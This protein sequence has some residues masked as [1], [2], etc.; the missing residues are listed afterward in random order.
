M[1]F[2]YE[3]K[4]Y[5]GH[6]KVIIYGAQGIALGTYNAIKALHPEIK[7]ECF[8]VTAKDSN[9]SLLGGIPVR[10][11][12]E[13]AEGKTDEEKKNTEVLIGTPENVME[14]IENNLDEAGLYNH[15]RIDSVKWAEMQE[16]AFIKTGRFM[17]LVS[18]PIY[19]EKPN[20]EMYKMRHHK[21]KQLK[22][23]YECPKYFISVQVGAAMAGSIIAE[24]TDNTGENI[25]YK[26]GNYSELTGLFWIWKNRIQK[27]DNKYYGLAHYRRFLELSEDDQSRLV[28]NNIDVV[29]PYP[30][31]YEPNIEAHH[32]RYLSD[33]EWN[34]VLQAL[35]ELQ[36]EYAQALSVILKKE[37]LYNYNVILAKGEV[38]DNYCSWLFPLLFRIEEINNPNGDKEPNRYIGYVGETLETLYFMHNKDKLKI[39]HAGCRFLV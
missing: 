21:D 4:G 8:L 14:A 38:L 5:F 1:L 22:A 18:Y 30:M 20:I 3:A 32:L 17:P 39:A 24:Y 25:S 27:N 13:F 34:A 37:Y 19:S 36:P 23:D 16:K 9:A 10:E 29:L 12:K 7:I 6:M 2:R 28:A 35:N 26:N 11:L 33:S 31:P 15:M